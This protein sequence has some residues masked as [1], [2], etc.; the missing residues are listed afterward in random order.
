MNDYFNPSAANPGLDYKPNGILGGYLWGQ[1]NDQYRRV[2]G[3][4]EIMAQLS[5]QKQAAENQDYQLNAPVRE[6]ARPAAIAKSGLETLHD[7]SRT[8][9]T[10]QLG[11]MAG[12]TGKAQSL[13]ATGQVDLG[14]A[15]TKTL[16]TNETNVLSA[17]G[18]AAQRLQILSSSKGS[19]GMQPEYEAVLSSLPPELRAHFPKI[20]GPEVQD[21]LKTI[22]DHVVNNP[23]QQRAMA[24]EKQ[25]GGNALD[26]AKEHSRG[27]AAAASISREGQME[28][29]RA[30]LEAK[31][32]LANVEARAGA[33]TDKMAKQGGKLSPEDQAQLNGLIQ[34]KAYWGQIAAQANVDRGRAEAAILNQGGTIKLPETRN[35]IAP[36]FQSTR[37]VT[38]PYAIPQQ[39]VDTT[40]ATPLEAASSFGQYQPEEYEYVKDPK[41]GRIGRIKKKKK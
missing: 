38:N 4:Q 16:S 17:L 12:E 24:L 30:N 14:T 40:P 10:F 15:A 2:M 41:T 20:Y 25:K 36:P 28:R 32:N 18:N 5:A 3:L 19:L 33:L 8:N 11:Q 27:A 1:Q 37:E 39:S 7:T 34:M 9:P 29:L 22:M 21:H 26:V 31:A 23:E 13:Q 35:P 6:A